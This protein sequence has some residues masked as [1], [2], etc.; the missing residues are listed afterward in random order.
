MSDD[1]AGVTDRHERTRLPWSRARRFVAVV[2]VV[3]VAALGTGLALGSLVVSPADREAQ[4]AAPPAGPITVPLEERVVQSTVTT[5]ADVTHADAVGLSPDLSGL[6]G[7]AVTTGRVPEVGAQLD[8]GSVALEIAGRPLLVLPG[9]LPAYRTLRAGMSGPDVAQLKTALTSLGIDSGGSDD[10]YDSSTASAVRELYRRSGYTAPADPDAEREARAARSAQRAAQAALDDARAA[11]HTAGVAPGGAALLEL[12]NAVREAQRELDVAVA[13]GA[14]EV[15]IA[16]LSDAL[17]LATA[18]RSEGAAAPDTAA[19]QAAV[20]AAARQLDDATAEA[21][22]AEQQALTPLPSSEVAFLTS[23]PRRVDSVSA[24][25]G[26]AASGEVM[27]VSGAELVLSGTVGESDAPLIASGARATFTAPDGSEHGATVR[28]VTEDTGTDKP[29]G[30]GTA[31]EGTAATGRRYRVVLVP[32]A[33]DDATVQAVR[34][35]NVRVSIPVQ[36]TDGAVLAAPIA[37]LT[38]GA[39]GESRLELAE[40]GGTRLVT[41]TTGLSAGGYVEIRSDDPAVVAG[42]RVV[43]G[44]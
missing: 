23:L 29:S 8:A 17:A 32:D 19:Q 42:S 6:A 13:G 24:A 27:T 36:S 9:E 5:R 41:V 39:G 1:G 31:A 4:N 30:G 14:P 7:A 18:R 16:R 38:S 25:R 33:L 21:A 28:S 40:E 35:R 10:V 3:A 44:R 12:D 20:D 43:V 2:S 22:R 11:L 26:K 34:D 15:D 37:A